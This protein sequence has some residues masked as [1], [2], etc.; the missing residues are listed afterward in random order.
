MIKPDRRLVSAT[1]SRA[2][3]ASSTSAT[4]LLSGSTRRV[5]EYPQPT[6]MHLPRLRT[7]DATLV[8]W[9]HAL[10]RALHGSSLVNGL[11]PCSTKAAQLATAGDWPAARW[12]VSAASWDSCSASAG[13]AVASRR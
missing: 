3:R 10:G 2:S 1:L 5:W 11:R 4:R 7:G 12:R 8:T 6:P 13:E 9:S